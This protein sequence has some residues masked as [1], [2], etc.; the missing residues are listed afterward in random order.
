MSELK[1]KNQSNLKQ[2]LIDLV[3]IIIIVVH[4]YG[5]IFLNVQFKNEFFNKSTETILIVSN[6]NLNTTFVHKGSNYL[7]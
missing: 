6:N 1:K 2:V 4:K 3:N 7:F 5:S